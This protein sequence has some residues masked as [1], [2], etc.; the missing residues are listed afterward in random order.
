VGLLE[1]GLKSASAGLS[2]QRG[3]DLMVSQLNYY[4]ISRYVQSKKCCQKLV[5]KST[6]LLQNLQVNPAT[7]LQSQPYSS[8][9]TNWRGWR[10]DSDSGNGRNQT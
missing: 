6:T 8:G 9:P 4:F 2:A 10:S 5:L 3:W 1:M 7:C